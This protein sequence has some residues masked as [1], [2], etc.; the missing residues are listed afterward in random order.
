MI[1]FICHEVD[2]GCAENIGGP[3]DVEHRT[4]TDAAK[5]EAWLRYEDKPRL[6]DSHYNRRQV[7]GAELVEVPDAR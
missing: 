4:F 2:S 6:R 5:L 3:V 1:R 7:I